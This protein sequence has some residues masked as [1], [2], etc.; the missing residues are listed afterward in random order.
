[1]RTTIVCIAGLA[2][3]AGSAQRPPAGPDDRSWSDRMASA[4]EHDQLAA[5]HE[6]AAGEAEAQ[7]GPGTLA[8]PDLNLN[9][10]LR[11]GGIGRVTDW[12]PCWDVTEEADMRHRYAADAERK[13]AQRDR[14]GAA[15]L[16]Q[17]EMAACRGI[18]E[19][20]RQH[21]VFAHRQEISEVIP[22]REAGQVRGA[23]IVF[24]PVPGVTAHW[25]R[26]D[27]DCQRARWALHGKPSNVADPTLVPGAQIQVV[28]R[29]G[30][31][32]VL[33]QTDTIDAGELALA[34][35]RG[36]AAE[37]TAVR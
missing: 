5:A 15:Q 30:H 6:Q 11:T 34:R 23:W 18:P 37:Q 25:V 16:A 24:K 29:H 1:M 3:C 10:Q 32:E 27:I 33:V 36:H 19:Q 12:Q 9:D 31:V 13:A 28:D 20:E 8:C 4:R 22:H 7:R 21:S 26:R 2:A 17:A 35:A 14:Q